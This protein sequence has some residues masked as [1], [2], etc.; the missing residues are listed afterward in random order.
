MLRQKQIIRDKGYAKSYFKYILLMIYNHL[1]H[2]IKIHNT[3]NITKCTKKNHKFMIMVEYFQTYLS[4][5]NG[6][7]C[8]NVD[9]RIFVQEK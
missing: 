7:N 2:R 3:K 5:T 8:K 4:E 6:L 1:T 9:C